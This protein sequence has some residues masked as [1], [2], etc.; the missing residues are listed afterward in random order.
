V[1]DLYQQAQGFREELLRGERRASADMVR[2]YGEVYRRL[3]VEVDRVRARIA[4]LRA[5]GGEVSPSLV[6]REARLATLEI[7]VREQIGEFAQRAEVIVGGAIERATELGRTH[8]GELID[9]VLPPG[10]AVGPTLDPAN[11]L[12][13]AGI[14]AAEA[15]PLATGAVEQIVAITQRTAPVGQLLATLGPEAAQAVTDALIS[16][17]TQGRNPR[18]I[19]SD[20]RKAL[21]GN[22]TRAMTIARTEVMRSYR[23][24]SRATYLGAA[25]VLDGWVW[26][27]DLSKRTCS[28]CWAQHGTLHP[29]TEIMA[30]HPRC[31][32]TMVPKTKP[33]RELG[34]GSTPEAVTIEPGPA[35]FRRLPA[36]DQRAILG[37]AKYAAYRAKEITL[38]DLVATRYS[39]TW[40]PSSGEAGLAAAREAAASRRAG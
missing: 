29:L 38:P 27:A 39:P 2:A 34:A 9:T 13:G 25:D 1:P 16:G 10:V 19:A 5:S 26:T 35:I 40:G 14:A 31:R 28:A 37:E 4:E 8:A 11:P 15:T 30:T 17:V 23:E 33:W 3:T 32:C 18:V 20:V 22:L 36:T 12:T 6:Y 21:G 7:Q 24:A